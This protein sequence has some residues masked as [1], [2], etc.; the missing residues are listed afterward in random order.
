MRGMLM[1]LTKN[2]IFTLLLW[3]APIGLPAQNLT[4]LVSFDGTNDAGPLRGNLVQGT[5]EELYG[6]TS[7]SMF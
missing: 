7:I 3:M 4:T 2:L 5:D 1:F 6:T